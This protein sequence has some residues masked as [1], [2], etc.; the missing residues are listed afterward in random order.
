MT[1]PLLFVAM[2]VCAVVPAILF[3]VNLRRYRPPISALAD[4]QR[5]AVLIPARN[6]EA[7]IAAALSA[8]L[9]STHVDLEVVV[10]DDAS[11]DR[12]PRIILDI[13]ARDP[14]VHLLSSSHLPAGWNGKQHACW[15]LS[16]ACSA[17]LMLFVDADVRLHPDAI[18]HSVAE[19]NRTGVALLSGFPRQITITFFEWLLL[20]LIHFVLLGFLPIGRMRRSTDP[21]VAAGCGQFLLVRR[22]AYLASGGHAAIRSTMHDGLRLPRAFRRAGFRT[23]LVDLTHLAEV[24]M[25]DSAANVWQGL[26]KNATEGIAAPATI[27]PI[28]LLLLLGQVLPTALLLFGPAL[29]YFIWHPHTFLLGV[30]NASALTF[31]LSAFLLALLASFLPRLLA[32][33][34]FCQPLKSALLHPLG[35]LL[36]LAI[37][38]YALIRQ[39]LRRPVGWR[40]RDYTSSTGTALNSEP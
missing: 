21:S 25:Y 1:L 5:V 28:T 10:L 23:D 26:A 17:P 20:P 18:A 37:Q 30:T 39:L 12:T 11:T 38:W 33:R 24:R 40:Q 13:A 9:A 19:L 8:V 2:F 15:Q 6:E 4:P 31:W 22:E 29:V 36:L 34:R 32:S 27:I 35:V 14:R 3:L 16:H 7:N